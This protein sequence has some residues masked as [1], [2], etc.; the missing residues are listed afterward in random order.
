MAKLDYLH[1][2][3]IQPRFNDFDIL[4]H[5]NNSVYQNY[6][7]LARTSYF[8]D[9]LSL[10]IDWKGTSLVLVKICIEYLNPI[11]MGERCTVETAITK[12]GTKSISMS[13]Q[14]ICDENGEVKTIN[15]AVLVA[16]NYADG[17]SVEIPKS[18]KDEFVRFEK[19]RKFN[20]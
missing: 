1:K 12:I 13:Q 3:P 20:L 5:V 15:D 11:L 9:V 2:T 6:F 18:W 14:I 17:I 4:G 8:N 10:P 16:F 7:D 19:G